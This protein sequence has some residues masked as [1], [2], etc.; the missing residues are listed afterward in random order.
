MGPRKLKALLGELDTCY[1]LS[2]LFQG[3]YEKWQTLISILLVIMTK[4]MH[5]LMKWAKTIPLTAGG[6]GS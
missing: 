6:G 2:S 5:S 3:H 1:N 4:W